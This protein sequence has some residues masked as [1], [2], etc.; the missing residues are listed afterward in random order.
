MKKFFDA[1][2]KVLGNIFSKKPK[3]DGSHDIAD[4]EIHRCRLCRWIVLLIAIPLTILVSWYTVSAILTGL[5]EL[6]SQIGLVVGILAGLYF[7]FG[8][9]ERSIIINDTTQAFVTLNVLKSIFGQSNILTVY[10][11][12]WHISYPWESRASNNNINLV[13]EAREFKVIV[14]LPGGEV[15]VSGNAIIRPDA[16]KRAREFLSGGADEVME[17]VKKEVVSWY[18][19]QTTLEK[20]VSVDKANK[21]LS[22]VFVVKDEKQNAQKQP[23]KKQIGLSLKEQFGISFDAVLITSALESDDVRKTRASAAEADI[24]AKAVM[25]SL[26]SKY[27]LAHDTTVYTAAINSGLITKDDI[28]RETSHL[29]ALSGNNEGVTRYEVDVKGLE[30]LTG[31]TIANVAKAFGGSKNAAA[32]IKGKGGSKNATTA[33]KGKGGKTNKGGTP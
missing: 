28:N 12:G 6:P 21:H 31:E 24:I 32:A 22:D 20:V 29:R 3:S 30:G 19:R 14:Q 1:L 5:F 8:I 18:S 7:S 16:I 23:G 33:P 11:P 25:S 4:D 10:G 17:V 13:A 15:T 26:C 9:V 27:G 2:S